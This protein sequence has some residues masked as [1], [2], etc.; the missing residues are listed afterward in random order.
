MV[1]TAPSPSR[2]SYVLI[3]L[4]SALPVGF[5][6]KAPFRARPKGRVLRCQPPWPYPGGT[7]Y[8][9]RYFRGSRAREYCALFDYRHGLLDSGNGFTFE[10]VGFDDSVSAEPRN[11][12]EA[13]ATR[14][15]RGQGENEACRS[16]HRGLDAENH[17]V[18]L[19]GR[20][21]FRSAPAVSARTGFLG[22]AACSRR[23]WSETHT[24]NIG[25]RAFFSTS[26]MRPG[27]SSR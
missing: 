1:V 19:T 13:A 24:R 6:T 14:P 17:P 7:V 21:V 18:W 4:S 25:C 3:A 16:N 22:G 27:S 15:S 2:L 11:R 23:S 9:G 20:A 26:M 10:T 12:P 5:T 8:D